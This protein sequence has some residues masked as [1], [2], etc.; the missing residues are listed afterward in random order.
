MY[1]WKVIDR[2]AMSTH[3]IIIS[4]ERDA[5]VAEQMVAKIKTWDANEHVQKYIQFVKRIWEYDKYVTYDA[6]IIQRMLIS[7]S[8]AYLLIST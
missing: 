5:P 3:F 6:F 4:L 7:I 8:R 2:V 1:W